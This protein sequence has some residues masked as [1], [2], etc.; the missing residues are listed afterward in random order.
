MLV[1]LIKFARFALVGGSGV[2]VDV[3]ILYVLASPEVAW[4]VT[5]SKI[6]AA[7][8]AMVNNYVWNDL[9]TFS[10]TRPRSNRLLDH[11]LRFLA[12]NGV[13]TVGMLWSVLLLNVFVRA[14]L[15]N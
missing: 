7:E 4:N 6:L 2:I 1:T 15:W 12:F 8:V 14:F 9:W 3:A 13:C 5:A 11:C 10:S